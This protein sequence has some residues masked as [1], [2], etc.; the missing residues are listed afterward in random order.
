MAENAAHISFSTQRVPTLFEVIAQE[1]L[2]ELIRPA[3]KQ[4]VEV[5]IIIIRCKI[6]FIVDDIRRLQFVYRYTV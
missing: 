6:Y 1:S 2:A 5:G 4:I 3:F